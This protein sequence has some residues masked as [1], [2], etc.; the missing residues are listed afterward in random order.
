MA[1][2][3]EKA[4]TSSIFSYRNL[5]FDSDSKVFT[6]N[7]SS[8]FPVSNL[9]SPIRGKAFKSKSSAKC[10]IVFDL[11]S[12]TNIDQ[13]N[14]IALI[15]SN[16]ST[17]AILRVKA[18]NTRSALDV[19]PDLCWDL[20]VWQRRNGVFV[21]LF[22][23][24]SFG[25]NYANT[26]FPKVQTERKYRFWQIDLPAN[27]AGSGI[28]HSLGLCWLGKS[29]EYEFDK[30]F[31]MTMNSKIDNAKLTTGGRHSSF[32]DRMYEFDFT[33]VGMSLDDAY[34][35]KSD[36]DEMNVNGYILIDSFAFSND[37]EKRSHGAFYGI[38]DRGSIQL[39]G[40]EIQRI[41]MTLGFKEMPR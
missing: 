5:I 19:S 25:R 7:E 26:T 2:A 36:F 21:F 29:F 33:V 17:G 34:E 8:Q 1:L 13:V 30:G 39:K 15:D 6:S 12:R 9:L 41:D 14:C 3:T 18:S 23:T 37:T 4:R 22:D 24:P 31:G 11:G 35:I 10:S 27:G 38:V 32:I 16:L 40:N 28:R 20:S